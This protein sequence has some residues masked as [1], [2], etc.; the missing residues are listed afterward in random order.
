MFNSYKAISHSTARWLNIIRVLPWFEQLKYYR[1]M[2][3]R[4]D[5]DPQFRPFLEGETTEIPQFYV[6]QIRKSLGPFWEWLPEGALSHDPNAY[7]KAQENSLTQ[8]E[9]AS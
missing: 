2:R 6:E 9:N 1:E 3:R 4:L 7:L 5:E 8:L